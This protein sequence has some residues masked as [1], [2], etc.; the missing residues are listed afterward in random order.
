[1]WLWS[2]VMTR[3]W[4]S[5]QAH[6]RKD[7]H[8]L[9]EIVGRNMDVKGDSGKD[10]EGREKDSRAVFFRLREYIYCH[11]ENFARNIEYSI[12]S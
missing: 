12:H 2:W 8:C 10:L 4:K 1:M 3:S 6:D 9:E 7:L 11:E 5:F